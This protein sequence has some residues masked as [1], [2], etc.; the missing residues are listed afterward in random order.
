MEI[1]NPITGL[2]IFKNAMPNAKEIPARLEKL[3]SED[4]DEIFKWNE[5]NITFRK[6][7]PGTRNCVD[8]KVNKF[9]FKFMKDTKKDLV[10]VWEETRDAI[11]SCL[12]EYM[13]QYPNMT[14]LDYME[15][16]NFVKYEPGTY[17]KPHIDHGPSYSSVLSTVVYFND[18]YEG[19]EL[20]FLYF[21]DYT[22][23][24]EAGDIAIFPS[25]F[26]YLH[27][28][29]NVISGQK[30]CAVTMFDFN[31]LNHRAQLTPRIPAAKNY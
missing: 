17:F 23:V 1:V 24:P 9:N 16:I 4:P 18:N 12:K 29:K 21:D 15:S 10:L 3:L 25:N 7:D 8:H 26:M 6:K 30:Y 22:Y 5:T 28:A 11:L 27:E 31:D 13:N 19:G 14:P 2:Y 20:R